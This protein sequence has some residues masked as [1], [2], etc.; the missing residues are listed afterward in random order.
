MCNQILISA[1][2]SRKSFFF[3][4][5]VGILYKSWDMNMMVSVGWLLLR[6]KGT[7]TMV[8]LSSVAPVFLL[9]WKIISYW[10][11]G[12]ENRNKNLKKKNSRLYTRR[13]QA[14]VDTRVSHTN[15]TFSYEVDSWRVVKKIGNVG[16]KELEIRILL[17]IKKIKIFH[18]PLFHNLNGKNKNLKCLWV[19]LLKREPK[20]NIKLKM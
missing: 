16:D 12:T 14:D 6:Q 13:S 17:R 10:V 11:L 3:P 18:Y 4:I 20:N 2:A 7:I 9:L 15:W 19:F 1:I 8:L 5:R